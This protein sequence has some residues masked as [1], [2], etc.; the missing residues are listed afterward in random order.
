MARTRGFDDG[1]FTLLAPSATRMM[2]RAHVSGIAKENL[3]FFRCARAL[4]FGYSF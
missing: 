4:I 2:I 3:G 1:R